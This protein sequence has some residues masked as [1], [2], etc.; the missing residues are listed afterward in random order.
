MA[1]GNVF[2]ESEVVQLFAELNCYCIRLLM[3]F[4]Y[5][6]VVSVLF[7][8]SLACLSLVTQWFSMGQYYFYRN[9]WGI[10]N[11]HNDHGADTSI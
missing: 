11:Y 3:L 9:Q 2:S 1:P 7:C 8:L 4:S 10:F 6:K 5:C